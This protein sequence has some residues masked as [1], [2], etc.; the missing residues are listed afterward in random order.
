MNAQPEETI[1]MTPE[2]Y[3]EFERHSEIK[4]EYFDGE[5]FAMIGASVNHN[6]I[7]SNIN[8]LLGNQLVN[9]PCDI[10]SN[11]M[12]VKIQRVKKYTYPDIAVV[13]GSLE[14][15]DQQFDTLLNPAV[16]IEILSKSTEA[17]DRGVKFQHYQ[18]IPSLKEYILVTQHSCR[19]EKYVRGNNG[20]WLYSSHEGMN[21]TMTIESINCALPLSEIYSRVE[22]KDR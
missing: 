21:Q 19:I 3:L 7:G 6:R 8:R 2:E 15:E 22:F 13:C 14:L 17:Y 4:H 5:I 12:R 11:D 9:R 18:L 1:Q 10:F 16:I 20:R